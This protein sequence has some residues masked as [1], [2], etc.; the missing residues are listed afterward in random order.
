L[1]IVAHD[2]DVVRQVHGALTYRLKRIQPAPS[3]DDDAM[4]VDGR[5]SACFTFNLDLPAR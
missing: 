1:K 4:D 5:P 2:D 3:T